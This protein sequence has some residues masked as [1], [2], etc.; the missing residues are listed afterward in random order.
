MTDEEA[1]KIYEEMEEF[2]GELP[3][4]EHHPIQFASKVRIFK[5]YKERIALQEAE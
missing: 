4:F 2:F 1:L 5:Y 3:N